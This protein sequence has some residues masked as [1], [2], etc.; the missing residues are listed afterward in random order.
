MN[1][2]KTWELTGYVIFIIDIFL[3][4][5][6]SLYPKQILS[7]GEQVIIAILLLI[8]LFLNLERKHALQE[9]EK[10]ID[11]STDT[12]ILISNKDIWNSYHRLVNSTPNRGFIR[13]M[14]FYHNIDEGKIIESGDSKNF[15]QHLAKKSYWS[16]ES[17]GHITYRYLT[18][19]IDEGCKESIEEKK[20]YFDEAK[21]SESFK[22]K[23]TSIDFPIDI[24]IGQD[25]TVIIDVPEVEGSL[26]QGLG[27]EI[28]DKRVRDAF[29]NWYDVYFW[30]DT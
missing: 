29:A 24:I 21:I 3:N 6:I 15:Y 9:I 8:P 26:V 23:I 10:K 16:K 28:R 11:S 18:N 25:D 13:A 1:M 5:F 22:S 20:S 14:N 7:T 19:S 27:I 4:I 17:G 2:K 30:K 12:N